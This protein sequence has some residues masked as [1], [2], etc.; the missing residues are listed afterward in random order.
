MNG[1]LAIVRAVHFGATLLLAGALA[2]RCLAAPVAA[3]AN[4]RAALPAPLASALGTRLDAMV[5]TALATALASGTA[6]LVLLSAEIGGGGVAEALDDGLP[7]TVLTATTFGQ[8]WLA[9]LAVAAALAAALVVG[10]LRP[11][12]AIGV[13]CAALGAVL[14]G[15]LAFAGH[16]AAGSG[17][18]GVVRLGSDVLHAVAAAC[19]LGALW[20]LAEVL[21]GARR[22]GGAAA[23]AVAAAVTRRFSV[24][25]MIS[26][27]T[28]LVTGAV[29]TGELLG[30][31]A[32]SAASGYNRL[33]YL[34]I[35]LFL[36]M[37]VIAVFNRRRLTPCLAGDGDHGRALRL[38][39]AT[40]LA[41]TALGIAIVAIVAVLGRMTPQALS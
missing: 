10:R 3:A 15:S 22:A 26:V 17:V 29:N 37:V 40:S 2:V 27:V 28:I 12:A 9:R 7:L 4:A 14:A 19:W 30:A 33:L 35:G 1:A 31:D 11:S 13:C 16:G 23:L 39:Q 36:A 41:E 6:W 24:L 21:G 8:A 5:W 32:F 18:E 25:G 38:L 34:K 20:P